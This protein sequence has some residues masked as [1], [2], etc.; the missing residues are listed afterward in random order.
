MPEERKRITLLG[1]DGPRVS[2]R[3]F[4]RTS[5]AGTA[6]AG[7]GALSACAPP[8]PPVV[9]APAPPAVAG[10][11]IPKSVA[12]YQDRPNRGRRCADCVHFMPPGACEIVAG[13]ISP[14]GWS[15]YFEPA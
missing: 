14:N 8:P 13:P 1:L 6:L 9:A 11:N 5:L 3:T 2:R 7:A 10:R 4:L 15:R 12:R